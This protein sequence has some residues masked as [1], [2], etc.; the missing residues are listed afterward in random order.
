[1]LGAGLG[2]RLRPLTSHRAKPL[3][4]VLGK[5]LIT[6]AFDHAIAHGASA[7]VVNTHHKPEA[8][9]EVLGAEQGHLDYRGVPVCFRNE[10]VLLD[11]GGGIRNVRDLMGDAPFLVHNGDILADLD[12]QSLLTVHVEEGNAA[13]LAL[14]S[15]GGPL[16]VAMDPATGLVTDIRGALGR[17]GFPEF[18]FTGIYILNPSVLDLLPPVGPASIV[19]VFLELIRRGERLR[20]IVLDEGFWADLGDLPSYRAAH[21]ALASGNP[22]SYLRNS[23]WPKTLDPSATMEAGSRLRGFN[24]IGARAV[25]GG[26][27]ILEDCILWPGAKTA[28][29]LHL[30]ACIVTTFADHSAEHEVL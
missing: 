22:L 25:V 26:D 6:Y 29:G 2:T 4:P 12:L 17:S 11:T 16:H 20:G 1:M 10:P 28:S 24:C 15:A 13:T 9:G 19:P 30:K 27:T 7:I 23:G 5:P 18:L 8:Y 3:V 21:R 14:R